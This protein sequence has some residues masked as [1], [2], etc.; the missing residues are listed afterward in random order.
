MTT[1]GREVETFL[2][3]SIVYS[4]PGTAVTSKHSVSQELQEIRAV[5]AVLHRSRDMLHVRCAD[6]T[7]TVSNFLRACHHQPLPFLDS[8]NVEGSIH[9]RFMRTGIE[10]SHA[11]PHHHH[12]QLLFLEVGSVD[13]G[14]FEF[15]A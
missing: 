15:A 3:A 4:A 14:D 2:I 12:F 10:P 9:Q 6:V 1:P 8:L 11:S 13:V 5:A 7:G